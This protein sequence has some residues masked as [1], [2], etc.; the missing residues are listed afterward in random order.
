MP[1]QV[2][3]A[4][5]LSEY[6]QLNEMTIYKLAREGK[7]PATRI[8]RSWRFRKDLIDQWLI[9]NSGYESLNCNPE[10]N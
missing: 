1:K 4:R 8:G 3:T 9:E 2:M 10:T 7:I 5:Q 6:L